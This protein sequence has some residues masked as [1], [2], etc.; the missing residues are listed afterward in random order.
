MT[1]LENLRFNP[2]ET[3]KERNLS[4]DYFCDQLS[5]KIDIFVNDAFG[6]MHRNHS[7]ITG[8]YAKE[9][10]AGFLVEKEL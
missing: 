4:K 5:H 3:Q 2:A 6:S 7:S 10:V 1:L 9:K 8:I